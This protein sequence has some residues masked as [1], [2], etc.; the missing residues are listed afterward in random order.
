MSGALDRLLLGAR[1]GPSSLFP[2]PLAPQFHGAS[3]AAAPVEDIRESKAPARSRAPAPAPVRGPGI[4][5]PLAQ[6]PRP[7]QSSMRPSSTAASPVISQHA[8]PSGDLLARPGPMPAPDR[9]SL[10]DDP[11]ARSAPSRALG[12]TSST[13]E[14]LAQSVLLPVSNPASFGGEFF[15]TTAQPDGVVHRKEP[16]A[17][18]GAPAFVRGA[19]IAADT[20]SHME[21]DASRPAFEEGADAPAMRAASSTH[22]T[23]R[24]RDVPA[25]EFVRSAS[26]GLPRSRPASAAQTSPP[27]G[28]DV[29]D[30]RDD[31]E[32]RAGRAARP[33][34][35]GVPANNSAEPDPAPAQ[36]RTIARER[37]IER[38]QE[39]VT[40]RERISTAQPA[41][42][43]APPAIH[44]TIGR[45]DVQAA[46][47][48]Q[49][50]RPRLAAPQQSKLSLDDYLKRRGRRAP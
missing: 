29:F 47:P 10:S 49:P 41:P 23:S 2:M 1:D 6:P 31:R 45:V 50:S 18:T 16:A 4:D 26:D 43:S 5:R 33:P 3:D 28:R 22:S 35:N 8:P 7:A 44:V 46:P 9:A 20:A 21:A 15:A 27:D 40:A 25:R 36:E 32:T 39:R 19:G 13:G 48:A 11:V 38:Q 42:A 34:A 37:V 12:R 24:A 17:H 30:E 14:S